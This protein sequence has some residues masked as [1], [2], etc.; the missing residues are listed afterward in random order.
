M[1]SKGNEPQAP[2][3]EAAPSTSPQQPAKSSGM[4]SIISA[5]LKLSLIHI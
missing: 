5:D 3:S 4:P 1:F 2:G